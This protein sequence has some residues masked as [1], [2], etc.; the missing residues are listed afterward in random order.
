MDQFLIGMLVAHVY[1]QRPRIAAN[2]LWLLAAAGAAVGGIHLFSSAVGY[3]DL[4]HPAWIVWT[5]LEGLLWA[6]VLVS[7]LNARI[8]LPG[9]V[10][11][12]LA[13]LGATSFS[14]YEMHNLV[15]AVIKQRVGLLPI[16]GDSFT[17]A[18]WTGLVVALPAAVAVA[19]A[20]YLLIERP[21]FAFRR[22]YLHPPPLAP[23]RR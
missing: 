16:G 19:A 11:R 8:T 14:I 17:Q 12:A 22:P 15:I 13:A 3:T 20:T 6:G 5:T 4:R 7:Y 21:F 10:D 1:L 18:L 2:P 23:R 9:G